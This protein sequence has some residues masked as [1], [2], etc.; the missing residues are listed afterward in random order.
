MKILVTAKRVPD[1]EQ[2]IKLKGN[3][4]DQS[5]HQLAAQP[6]RRVRRRDGAAADRE[7]V[8][9]QRARRRGHGAVDRAQGRAAAA[10]LDPGD[11]RRQGGPG[12]RRRR[13]ARRRDRGAHGA[14]AGRARQ[15]RPHPHGQARR[16]LRGQ[17]R[18]AAPRRLSRLAAGDLRRHHRSRRRR[19]GAPGRPRGRRR[20]RD[21]EGDPAGGGDGRSAHRRAARGQERQDR[22]RPRL[23]RGPA[24]RVA[25]G[26]HGGQEEA[27][28]GDHAAGARRHRRASAS[29]S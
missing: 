26:H 15:A 25:Q 29:R 19:Q 8:G 11:G 17:R 5:A 22:P 27:D 9:G 16:R 10:A 23:R 3:E 21:Q 20:P 6:V 24:L 18:R 28:R 13:A 4:L 14:E 1:P 12:R 2:K 7:R